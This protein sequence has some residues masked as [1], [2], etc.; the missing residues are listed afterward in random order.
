MK[1]I[2]LVCL[3]IS[4]LYA[5]P[6]DPPGILSGT[7]YINS[8]I[9]STPSVAIN[10]VGDNLFTLTYS[11]P[12]NSIPYFSLA[13]IKMT[14][15]VSPRYILLPRI[16]AQ[17]TTNVNLNINTPFNTWINLGFSWI[18]SVSPALSIVQFSSCTYF[19]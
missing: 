1:S 10:R 16:V 19:F 7:I 15:V 12:F 14:S 2:L 5:A 3:L 9:F 18:A 6:Q 11:V 4:T 17:T 8:G 13:I